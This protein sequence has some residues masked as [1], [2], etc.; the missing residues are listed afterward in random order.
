MALRKALRTAIEVRDFNGADRILNE[1]TTVGV[2]PEM[3][4]SIAVLIGRLK[5][6]L[7]RNADALA[8]YR[9]AANSPDRRAAA[10]GRLREILLRYTVGDMPR[11]ET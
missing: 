7:G 4:P 11:K 10:Q 5:E 1:I 3:T 9:A 2:P 6:A 8:S